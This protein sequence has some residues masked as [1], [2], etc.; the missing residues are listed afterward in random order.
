MQEEILNISDIKIDR[1]L[2]DGDDL[3]DLNRADL[4]KPI[5]VLKDGTLVDGLR[6]IRKAQQKKWETIPAYVVSELEDACEALAI[7]HPSAVTNWPRMWEIYSILHPLLVERAKIIRRY[8]NTISGNYSQSLPGQLPPKPKTS[9]TSRDMMHKAFGGIGQ[10]HF[11]ALARLNKYGSRQL[12]DQVMA[13][14]ITPGA[15]WSRHRKTRNVGEV[16]KAEDQRAL[17]E[18][19]TSTL[20]AAAQTLLRMGPSTLDREELQSYL[21]H[22]YRT[23]SIISRFMN[24][25]EEADN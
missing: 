23:R 24:Q 3:S 9:G 14:Q 22:L 8:V 21:L 25:L 16:T 5:V 1:E 6:R 10:Y 11:E 18:S 20:R 12:W 15:A 2:R 17:L 7:Q 4:K 13:N 19:M